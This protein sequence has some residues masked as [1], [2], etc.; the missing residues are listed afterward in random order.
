MRASASRAVTRLQQ[1]LCVTQIALGVA[2]LSAAALLAHSLWR[3][4]AVDPG[5]DSRSVLGFNLSVPNDQLMPARKRFYADALDEIRTIPGVERAGLISFLPPETRAGVFM[6]LAIDGVPPPERDAPPRVVNTLITSPDYFATMRMV[7]QRGRDFTAADDTASAPVIIVNEAMARRYF[8]DSD[9]VGRRIG[10]GF[11]GLKP[12]RTIVGVVRDSHDRGLAAEPIPTAYIPFAQFALPYGSI[13][14]R[15]Q[16]DPGSVIPVIRDRLNR[17]NPAVPVTDFQRLDDRI[18][19]SLREP[20]FYT[21]MAV[22]CAS[23]A[24]LFVTFGLY[25]LVSYSVSRRTAEL[26]IRMAVGAQRTTILG[27]VVMQGLRMSVAGVVLGLGLAIALGRAM[28]S[29]LFQVPP[30][31]T[32]TLL[33]S[34]GVVVFVTLLACYAPARRASLVNPVTALRTE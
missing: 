10:T 28:T 17:L 4:H 29:L 9:A 15:T 21:L 19:E 30:A 7:I 13:A 23:M 34:A 25:G 12:V 20:R 11:D 14:L 18:H 22:A 5:F 27:M 8:S 26:G 31:D 32:L 24:V 1:A 33:A 3:L 6:G 2:L 16:V